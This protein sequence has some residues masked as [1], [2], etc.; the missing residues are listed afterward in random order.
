MVNALDPTALVIG[1]GLGLSEVYRNKAVGYMRPE[2]Y[3][4]A[5]RAINVVPAALGRDAGVIGAALA[6]ARD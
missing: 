2:I 3:A 1:G 5:T 4:D 6:T